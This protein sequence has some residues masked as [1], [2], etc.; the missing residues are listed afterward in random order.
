MF[1]PIGE[2]VV[3]LPHVTGVNYRNCWLKKNLWEV[4]GRLK[5]NKLKL[6][7]LYGKGEVAVGENNVHPIE[8]DEVDMDMVHAGF[9]IV[10]I[11]DE[12]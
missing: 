11:L 3:I 5:C 8:L 6:R 10:D 4:T 12:D 2:H 1:H 7:W 9:Q